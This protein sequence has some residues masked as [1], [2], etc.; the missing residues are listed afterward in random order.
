[1]RFGYDSGDLGSVTERI[2]APGLIARICAN[3]YS[4]GWN[5][6][7]MRPRL[8]HCYLEALVEA[9]RKGMRSGWVRKGFHKSKVAKCC[10]SWKILDTKNELCSLKPDLYRDQLVLHQTT[11]WHRCLMFSSALSLKSY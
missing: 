11:L 4:Q 6:R 10:P 3:R 8:P 1:M 7:E 5:F 9:L 2:E